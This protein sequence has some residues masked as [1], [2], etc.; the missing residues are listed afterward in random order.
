MINFSDSLNDPQFRQQLVMF[1]WVESLGKIYVHCV[2]LKSLIESSCCFLKK[3]KS[4]IPARASEMTL[5]SWLQLNYFLVPTSIFFNWE[6]LNTITCTGNKRE[7]ITDKLI[8]NS[9]RKESL[10]DFGKINVIILKKIR[11]FRLTVL[12]I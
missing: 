2:Q 10:K 3:K 8:R 1:H 9:E 11:L 5:F 4:W 7:S 6:E 12:H